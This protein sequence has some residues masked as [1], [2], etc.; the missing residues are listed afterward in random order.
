MRSKTMPQGNA[1][2]LGTRSSK[3]EKKNSQNSMDNATAPAVELGTTADAPQAVPQAAEDN[4]VQQ[5]KMMTLTLK[6]LSKNGKQ[7]YYS[8]AAQIVRFVVANF[9]N[10]VAPATIEIPEG[11]FVTAAAKPAPKAKLTKEERAAL[12]KPTLAEKAAKARERAD[13]LA[14]AAAAAEQ[15]AL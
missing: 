11:V 3:K 8:G 4:P 14:A 2:P 6:T 5:E 12:P 15:P 1:K 7:A 10:K 9:V 13:K